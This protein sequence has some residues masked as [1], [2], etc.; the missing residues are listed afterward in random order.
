MASLNQMVG[1]FMCRSSILQGGTVAITV[2]S[3]E[4]GDSYIMTNG[5]FHSAALLQM[6]GGPQ[7]VQDEVESQATS[8]GNATPPRDGEI[9]CGAAENEVTS[10]QSEQDVYLQLQA[11][12]MLLSSRVLRRMLDI[13]PEAA[14]STSV[15]TCSVVLWCTP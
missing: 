1:R 6:E 4:G 9:R 13:Q 5:S 14:A 8:D 2:P 12:M 7:Q 11:N 10:T 3:Q 15:I